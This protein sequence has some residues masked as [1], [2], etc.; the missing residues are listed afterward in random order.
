MKKFA[1]IVAGGSGNRMRAGMPKQFIVLGEKPLLMHTIKAFY[2][3]DGSMRIVLVLPPAQFDFWKALCDTYSFDI[4]HCV[5]A[6]GESRF[7][8]VKNGLQLIENEEIIFIHD[9]VRPLVSRQTIDKCYRQACISG[10]AVPVVP[11]SESVRW[12][13]GEKNKPVERDCIRLVQTPQ[14]FR[15]KL[16][17]KAYEQSYSDTFTD[18][19]SVVEKLGETIYLTEGNRENIKITWAED[20]AI[21]VFY[22]N[23]KLDNY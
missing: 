4:P 1:L 19:A 22:M 11:V 16:I 5:A 15:A 7:H 23:M 14:T 18:D 12:T 9:G 8:S 17:K 10:N 6:G 13:D 3:Y 2:D 20:F 21:A